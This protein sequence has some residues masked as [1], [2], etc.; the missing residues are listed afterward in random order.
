M[1]ANK[2]CEQFGLGVV[3]LLCALAL[4]VARHCKHARG[5]HHGCTDHRSHHY[6]HHGRHCCVAS[7]RHCGREGA[8]EFGHREHDAGSNEEHGFNRGP[9]RARDPLKILDVRFSQG[10]IDEA[11]YLRRRAIL[12]DAE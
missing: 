9:G 7:A 6:R 4:S 1:D 10:E 12:M 5:G 3:V 2:D 8:S 11:E